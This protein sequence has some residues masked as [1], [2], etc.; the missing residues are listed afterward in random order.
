MRLWFERMLKHV[1]ERVLERVLEHLPACYRGLLRLYPSEL[2]NA[3]GEEM[4]AVF[5]QLIRDE[6]RRSG[7]R[8]VALASMHALGE[9][10][11][12]ALPLY[13]T[14]DWLIA[15]SLSVVIS[16]GVLGSLVGIMTAPSPINHTVIHGRR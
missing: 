1:L 7:S 5:Q 9:L 12:V 4:A 2:R 11:T 16:L 3:Y 13:L 6:H 14:S 10:F 15:A 8:G